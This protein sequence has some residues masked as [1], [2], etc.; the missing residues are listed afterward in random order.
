MEENM[1]DYD[2]IINEYNKNIIQE[3][4]KCILIDFLIPIPQ[5]IP[6]D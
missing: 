3:Y 2:K 4:D 6:T 1:K 5:K